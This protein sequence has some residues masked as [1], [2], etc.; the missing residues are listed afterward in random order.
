MTATPRGADG[1]R[2]AARDSR[3]R[4]RG[5][6]C[7]ARADGGRLPGVGLGSVWGRAALPP[8]PRYLQCHVIGAGGQQHSGRVP[9]DGI[10]LVLKGS[11]KPAGTAAAQQGAGA[12]ELPS[13]GD[14]APRAPWTRTSFA[15]GTPP[16][17]SPH[18][19]LL[20]DVKAQPQTL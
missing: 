3:A 2:R 6:E 12:S 7:S 13:C 15:P 16:F 11:E 19:A 9:L 10:D 8:A 18:S 4:H 5:R 1:A 17:S 20:T 14:R